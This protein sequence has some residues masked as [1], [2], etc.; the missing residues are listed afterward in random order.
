MTRITTPMSDSPS[1]FGRVLVGVGG[2]DAGYEACR[3]AAALAAPGAALEAVAVVHLAD[4]IQVGLEAQHAT[5]VLREDAE[6]AL[7]EARRI[8]GDRAEIRFLN[9]FVTPTL[10]REIDAFG[11]TL[12]A[13]GS[14][15]HHRL[16]E[17]MIGGV[18]GEL[19]HSAPCSVLLARRRDGPGELP[20]RIVVGVDGSAHTRLALAAA[21]ELGRAPL[22]PG[23]GSRRDRRQGR[24]PR[25]RARAR[26]GGARDRRK[27]GGCPRR[28]RGRSEPARR[29][30][31]RAARHPR[32]RQRLGAGR[33]SCSLLGPRRPRPAGRVTDAPHALAAGEL[34]L[35]LDTD[36]ELG[37]SEREAEARLALF[38]PNR[39][40]QRRRP[41][42][43][44]LA[45]NQLVDPLVAL[46]AAAAAISVAV[47]DTTEGAAIAA[48]LVLNGALGFWQEATADRA[49]LALTRAFTQSA[50]VVRDGR[51]RSLPAEHVVPGDLLLV[52]AGERV[53]A[54]ARLVAAASVEADESALTGESLPVAKE[55]A[56]VARAAPLAD[57]TSM[58]H[59]G[60]A[61]TRG[62]GRALVCATGAGTE[63]GSIQR[64][65]AGARAPTTPLTRRLGRLA[66]QMVV[67]GVAITLV[68]GAA[69]LLRGAGREEAF[70]T[71]VAVAV[72]AVPEGLA[73][74]VTAALALGAR[75]MADR[76]AIVRTLAAI[77]TLGATTVICTDKTG[78]LT[79]NRIRVAALSPA[80]DSSETALLEAA[81][82]ASD[83]RD[84]DG[85]LVGDPIDTA[86]V[87]AA[88]ERGIVRDSLLRGRVRLDELPFTSE[89]KRMTV[90]YEDGSGRC[91]FTKGAPEALAGL[92]DG[93]PAEI[94]ATAESWAADGLRV[95]AVAS[96][97]LADGTGAD[98]A[99]RQ[100]HLLGGIALHDPLR[101]SAA[102]AVATADAAGISVRMLTGDHP[103]TARTIGRSLGLRED[104]IH[105]RT[106]PA[107]KLRL[108]QELQAAGEVV[109]VTGDGV[110]DAPA[111]RQADVGVAMGRS[112]TEAA[113]EA[114]AIV[115]TDDDFGTIVAAVEEGRRIGDN[116]RTFVAFLLSANLGEVLVFAV[117]IAVGLGSPLAVIQVLV[118]NLVTDGLPAVALAHDPASRD[119]MSSPPRRGDSLFDRGTWRRL[120]W[121]GVLVGASTL[122]AFLVGRDAGGAGQTMAFATLALSELALVYGMRS[123]TTAAWRL[124][125][126]RW[127]DA[128]VAVSALVVVLAVVAPVAHGTFATVRL[129]LV[130]WAVVLALSLVPL[131]AVEAAKARR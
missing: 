64:L 124:R 101:S 110:N 105:A 30:Q 57:R 2:T 125:S 60:T 53:A 61:V 119:T 99:E 4:A 107:D 91:A 118:V 69:M 86:L 48:I 85:V 55:V 68:L 77:E 81:V 47:G 70:L 13:I 44:R 31:P 20:G 100:L 89:R 83:A 109:A 38:G 120:A 29:R 12:V 37:L 62:S 8:L 17:I 112:G 5:D 15:G 71:A 23:R 104:A 58:L 14:H 10:L 9:G 87:A 128:S 116:I 76:G 92:A 84:V 25:R 121:I 67:L 93:D 24:R 95:L 33:P 97:R 43:A 1:M 130:E 73:A 16:T 50:L 122:A 51:E 7:A 22:G 26:A 111:L 27:R 72:A 115:V 11:A 36:L 63:M 19:L 40:E 113:R 32:P 90:V 52:A 117:A 39:P 75:A 102:P 6:A 80:A 131:A 3:Q 18:A 114:A 66:R 34:A 88:E 42:Y 21:G 46:L 65:A 127:L 126:N 98:E 123:P 74:T 108:V 41:R 106:T 103:A 28:R 79:Q 49:V 78:T 82:L 94:L 129:D 96:R 35:A 45:L 56:P 54:D 59:A